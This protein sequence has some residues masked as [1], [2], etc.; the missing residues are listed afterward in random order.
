MTEERNKPTVEIIADNLPNWNGHACVVKATYNHPEDTAYFVVSTI[1]ASH[2]PG[3]TM[4]ETMAF[5]SDEKGNVASWGEVAG[6]RGATREM[7]IEQIKTNQLYD[8]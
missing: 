5:R 7:V 1:T 8:W 3:I 4:D 2:I 6:G